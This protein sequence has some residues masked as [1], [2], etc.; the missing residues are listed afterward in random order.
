MGDALLFT[1]HDL[2]QNIGDMD[3]A[4]I[5]AVDYHL[6]YVGDVGDALLFTV[7]DPLQYVWNVGIA[8]LLVGSLNIVVAALLGIQ[9]NMICHYQI[10][11]KD[12]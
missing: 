9:F 3:D 2:L 12:L 6:Q 5:F 4:L 10:P 7:N 8:H 1:V 11:N